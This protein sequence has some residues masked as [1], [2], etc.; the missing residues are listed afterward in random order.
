MLIKKFS[1][2]FIIGPNIRQHRTRDEL[3]NVYGQITT[4]GEWKRL[5]D[6]RTLI[7]RAVQLVQ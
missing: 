2:F 1:V 5:L 7:E 6:A 3:P 4:E